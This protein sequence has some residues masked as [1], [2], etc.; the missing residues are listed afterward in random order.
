[1]S[2]LQPRRPRHAAL[3][4][5]AV[6]AIAVVG[7]AA[8][9]NTLNGPLVFDD[10]GSIEENAFIRMGSLDGPQL[11]RAAFESPISNRPVSNL[12]FALNYYV[13]RYDVAGYHV[14]NI[15]VHL[16]N[17]ILV[18]LLALA[19]FRQLRDREIRPGQRD[20]DR[21]IAFPSLIAALVF[22]AHP[23]QTQS[24]T[25]VVQRMNALATLFYLLALLLYIAG[26]R[27]RVPALRWPLWAAGFASWILSLG[28][29]EITVT[30]P[31]IVLLY[32]WCFF[33]NLSRGWLKRC[34]WFALPVLVLFAV[35]AFVYLGPDPWGRVSNYSSRDFSMGQRV[36]TQWRVVVLYISLLLAPLPWR[37]NLGHDMATSASL[38]DPITTLLCLILHVGLLILAACGL[39]R[40]RLIG[41]C[42]LWFFVN[43][44]I[45]SS[46]LPLE[47]VFE[48]RLYLPM[49][50]G[51]LLAACLLGSL[52][53]GRRTWS[54]GITSLVILALTTT[55]HLR[56]RH[57]Q[58]DLTLWSDVVGKSPHNH[59]ART[60]LGITLTSLDRLQEAY[61]H[62]HEALRI[63]PDYAM[64]HS[65]M[66][67]A[68]R[69]ERRLDEALVRYRRALQIEPNNAKAHNNLG[70]TL[71]ELGRLTEAI[72]HYH[73]ALAID[74][75]YANAHNNLGTALAKSG[76]V[77][78]A[79]R[80]HR[81]ALQLLPG[82]AGAH[83]NL[84][85]ALGSLGRLADAVEEFSLALRI[86]P[87]LAEAH[88]NM[89]FALA[90]MGHL[91]EARDHYRRAVAGSPGDA[92]AHDGLAMV[93]ARQGHLEQA[94][95]HAREA[96][97]IDPEHAGARA[98]L[99][100]I[101]KLNNDGER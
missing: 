14:V 2:D 66:G 61:E 39:T 84:G 8:Y 51:A 75:Q 25:Y 7:I 28:S 95:R 53:A 5:A 50:G 30:L 81:R 98:R 80:H 41:F 99:D 45:E 10:I 57:W 71:T 96:L 21:R 74:S 64:A 16:V 76:R 6:A 59:R 54:V 27:S 35:L 15:A 22:V 70:V 62:F 78:A 86:E 17:G 88:L 47:M 87:D 91:D 33:Q 42:I 18:Y 4:L 79:L 72:N 38:F 43:L 37:L 92:R 36:M 29:K 1:M 49:V 13:G 44:A 65:S 32:E 94:I 58:D 63:K 93:S 67:N 82:F 40:Y 101:L 97:R 60:D 11:V 83:V 48:H 26:R 69:S 100:A 68:L 23:V 19:T 3:N 52:T 85:I 34:A 9:A 56:N 90:N 12:S 24:V 73:R 55:S 89:G 31:L 77:E 20:D 46:I